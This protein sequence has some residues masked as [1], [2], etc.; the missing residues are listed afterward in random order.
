M[1]TGRHVRVLQLSTREYD[2]T[3]REKACERQRVGWWASDAER[4]EAS[5]VLR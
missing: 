3:F 1:V 2:G 5:V 4:G